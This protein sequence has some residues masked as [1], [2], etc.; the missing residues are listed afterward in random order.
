MA[1]KR[2]HDYS[3]RCLE[4]PT[5]FARRLEAARARS[6]RERDANVTG[7]DDSRT[8]TSPHPT[9]THEKALALNLDKR[10]YGTIAEIG[11]GQE[12]ARWFF[13]VGGAAGTVAKTISAYD[14][15]VSDAMYGRAPRYVSRERLQAMLAPPPSCAP[16]CR[17]RRWRAAKAPVVERTLAARAAASIS[18]ARRHGLPSGGP[19]IHVAPSDGHCA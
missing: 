7:L 15:A 12:V 19:A 13:V 4:C 10:K 2:S 8:V 3:P 16:G 11:A 17:T 1:L 9:A 18:G 14:M 6:K 5:N